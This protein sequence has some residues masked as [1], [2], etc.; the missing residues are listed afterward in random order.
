MH[1]LLG[2]VEEIPFVFSGNQ[3]VRTPLEIPLSM[4]PQIGLFTLP[5]CK[6][7]YIRVGTRR[8]NKKED[9]ASFGVLTYTAFFTIV[10]Y[11]TVKA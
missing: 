10:L 8:A 4:R 1:A 6:G 2:I 3:S 9:L 7:N 11:P 5:L